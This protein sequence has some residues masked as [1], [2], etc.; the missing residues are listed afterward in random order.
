MRTKI[1]WNGGWYFSKSD[2]VPENFSQLWIPV[3]L[4]HTWNAVDGQDGG[5]DYYRG[6][7]HYSTTSKHFLSRN[8][9]SMERLFWNFKGQQ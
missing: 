3:T 7:C 2:K 4:P 5:N 8:F 1:N 6:T 9:R